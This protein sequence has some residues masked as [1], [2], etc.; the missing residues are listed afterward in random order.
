MEITEIT[1]I[2]KVMEDT[3]PMTILAT[4]TTTADTAIMTASR[5]DTGSPRGEADT[6]T[7]SNRIEG[8]TL[9]DCR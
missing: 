3:A 2:I 1:D 8:E 5:V 9:K 7:V 6:P 4:T